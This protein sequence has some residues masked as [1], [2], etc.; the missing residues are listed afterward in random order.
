MV[1]VNLS[2]TIVGCVLPIVGKRVYQAYTPVTSG[3]TRR[4]P[5][6]KRLSAFHSDRA[7]RPATSTAVNIATPSFYVTTGFSGIVIQAQEL[8]FAV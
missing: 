4:T 6:P 3:H 2:I 1:L 5:L 7:T 8:L